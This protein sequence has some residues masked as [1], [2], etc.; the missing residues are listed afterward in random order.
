MQFIGI[1][2]GRLEI[3]CLTYF[4]MQLSLKKYQRAC[5]G[6]IL[7]TFFTH[8]DDVLLMVMKCFIIHIQI[9]SYHRVI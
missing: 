2:L 4:K 1:M 9:K 5:M 7:M 3:N 6:L 8:S